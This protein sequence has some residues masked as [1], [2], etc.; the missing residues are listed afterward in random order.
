MKAE[1]LPQQINEMKNISRI[2]GR[3][4]DIK[5]CSETTK[6]INSS[7]YNVISMI[8]ISEKIYSN[9]MTPIYDIIRTSP[10]HLNQKNG[11]H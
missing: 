9:I 2:I 1:S 6:N 11:K 5:L 3:T 10:Q 4:I 8:N 7:V